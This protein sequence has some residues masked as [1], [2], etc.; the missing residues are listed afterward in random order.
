MNSLYRV[1]EGNLT[2][3][4]TVCQKIPVLESDKVVDLKTINLAMDPDSNDNEEPTHARPES[5]IE[6]EL[7][8]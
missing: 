4:C 5:F 2:I 3:L 8:D 1:E 6:F 7:N